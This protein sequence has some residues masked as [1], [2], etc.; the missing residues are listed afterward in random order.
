MKKEF[1]SDLFDLIEKYR[2]KLNIYELTDSII[3]VIKTLC[4]VSAKENNL[5]PL[6]PSWITAILNKNIEKCFEKLK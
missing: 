5:I 6:I 2:D 3:G 1:E 4:L